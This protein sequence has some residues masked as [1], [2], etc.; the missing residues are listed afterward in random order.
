MC[1]DLLSHFSAIKGPRSDKNKRYELEEILL[2]CVY[3]V[4][5]GAEGW[6]GI[7]AFG[8]TKLAWLRQLLPY[9]NGIPSTDCLG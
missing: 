8:R 4:R 3:A 9:A 7:C 2:L 1:S 6:E 5:S